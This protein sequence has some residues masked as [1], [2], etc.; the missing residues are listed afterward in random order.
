MPMGWVLVELFFNRAE[1]SSSWTKQASGVFLPQP[2]PLGLRHCD[3]YRPFWTFFMADSLVPGRPIK[4]LP[5][6]R[7]RYRRRPAPGLRFNI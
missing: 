6:E 2:E 1:P 5:C 7:R 4:L 3:F